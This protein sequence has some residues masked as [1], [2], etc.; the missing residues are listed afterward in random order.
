MIVVTGATGQAGSEVVR[1]LTG[2]SDRVRAFVR[3]PGKARHK[4]GG[5]VELAAGDFADLRSV[6]AALDGA[7]TLFL[8]CADDPRRVGWETSAIEAAAAAGVHRIVKLSTAAAEPGSPVAFWDWHGQVEQHLRASGIAWVILRPSWYM[9]NLSAAAPQV[10]AERRLYAPAGQAR[11]AMIDPRD[12]GAAAAA[13]LSSPGH[14][15]QTYLLTGPEAITFTQ[16]AVELSAAAASRIEFID[17]PGDDAHKALT[18]GGMPDFAAEQIVKT[19]EQLRLG[20][21]AQV[22]ATV[23]TLTGS[24]PRDFTSFARDY[25]H[26]FAPTAAAAGAER[27]DAVSASHRSTSA[28]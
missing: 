3:D 8:S 11:I 24:A 6:R 10:A 22:T 28:S 23:A 25:A 17:I 19:F 7:D 12:V 13:V 5:T 18:H 16:V 27:Q 9:S 2:R 15:G 21:A 14:E 4:L 20:A 1:A 26:L